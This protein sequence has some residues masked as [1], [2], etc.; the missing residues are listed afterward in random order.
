MSTSPDRVIMAVAETVH[1]PFSFLTN[2]T[3]PHSRWSHAQLTISTSSPSC[4]QWWPCSP[5]LADEVEA[6]SPG[7]LQESLAS[8][9]IL[10]FLLVTFFPPEKQVLSSLWW[11][12]SHLMTIRQMPHIK[13]NDRRNLASDD[14]LEFC[15]SSG[16]FVMFKNFNSQLM[17]LV[18]HMQQIHS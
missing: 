8:Q 6:K 9:C 15:T 17:K 13:Q 5:I 18:C 16:L 4:I 10:P 1:C 2:R 7:E 11:C 14:I 3:R 12:S